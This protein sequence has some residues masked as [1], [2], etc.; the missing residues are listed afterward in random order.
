[1]TL[2]DFLK[3]FDFDSAKLEIYTFFAGSSLYVGTYKNK[4]E[5][6]RDLFTRSYQVIEI[7]LVDDS[8]LQLIIRH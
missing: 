4:T 7:S 5:V 3:T 2:A 6:E 8:T 1:M